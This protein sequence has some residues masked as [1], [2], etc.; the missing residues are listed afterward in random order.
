MTGEPGDGTV[1]GAGVRAR[2][3]LPAPAGPEPRPVCGTQP[4][5]PSWRRT[6]RSRRR[7][8]LWAGRERPPLGTVPGSGHSRGRR[9]TAPRCRDKALRK[10]L[11]ARPSCLTPRLKLRPK[12]GGARRGARRWAPRVRPG[13]GPAPPPSA[14]PPPAPPSPRLRTTAPGPPAPR[15]VSSPRGARPVL[16]GKSLV[17]SRHPRGPP[18]EAA[19]PAGAEQ[20][21]SRRRRTVAAG[22]ISAPARG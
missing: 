11:P 8:P 7:A 10:G 3:R 17:R 12:A 13:H 5:N 4:A 1:S 2:A 19:L 6:P 18:G 14:L 16:P 20:R 21:C 15:P 22:G 9:R